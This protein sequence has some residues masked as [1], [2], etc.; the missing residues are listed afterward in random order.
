[1][2]T[3]HWLDAV[4]RIPSSVDIQWRELLRLEEHAI[5]AD[6]SFEPDFRWQMLCKLSGP[7]HL[8]GPNPGAGPLWKAPANLVPFPSPA[9]WGRAYGR[10]VDVL[11]EERGPPAASG[12]GFGPKAG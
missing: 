7:E 6:L 8:W 10:S 2:A 12:V 5:P 3:N 4:R 11:P 9:T 1:M